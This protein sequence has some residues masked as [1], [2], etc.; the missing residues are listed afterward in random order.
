MGANLGTLSSKGRYAFTVSRPT[1]E[2]KGVHYISFGTPATDANYIVN[3]INQFTGQC[4]VW[5][6]TPPTAA[7][8]HIVTHALTT[9]LTS[10]NL[11]DSTFHFSVIV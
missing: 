4:K 10:A 6:A 7:G 1:A 5:E 2:A 11:M 8:F 9:A 3:V